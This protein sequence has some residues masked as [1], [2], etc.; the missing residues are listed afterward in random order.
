ATGAALA[1]ALEGGP[2]RPVLDKGFDLEQHVQH[3]EREY[4]AEALR[5]SGGGKVKAAELLGVSF[6]PVRYYM[7]KYKL[8]ETA[9]TP[10]TRL[11]PVPMN[12]VGKAGMNDSA[13]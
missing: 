9:E 6:R 7:K 10:G 4:I 1:A 12:C 13:S 11:V 2:A 3:L 8:K 5:R